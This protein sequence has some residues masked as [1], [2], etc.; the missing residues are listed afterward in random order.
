MVS[1]VVVENGR[2]KGVIYKSEDDG[3]EHFQPA[4]LVAVAGYSIETPRL[5]LLSAS[6]EFP[7]GLCNDHGQVGHYLMVQGAPQTAGRFDEEVRMYK[8]PPPEVTSED[9]YE[10]DPHQ[11]VPAGLRHP[12]RRPPADHLC[13][14]RRRPGP[15]G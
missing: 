9:F 3:K 2:A 8:A 5:L 14:A 10:T 7:D 11:A 15:L 6:K 1:S 13:R 12:E 4:R